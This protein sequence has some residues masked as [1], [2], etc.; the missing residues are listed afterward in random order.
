MILKGV[1]TGVEQPKR[2]SGSGTDG[3]LKLSAGS[4]TMVA[5]MKYRLALELLQ[6]LKGK[7]VV[8]NTRALVVTDVRGKILYSSAGGGA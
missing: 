3:G 5:K 7:T 2:D 4:R 6:K 8:I 1:V